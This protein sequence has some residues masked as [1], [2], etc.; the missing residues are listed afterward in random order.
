MPRKVELYLKIYPNMASLVAA[1]SI[2]LSI[3]C[4]LCTK[5]KPLDQDFS[6]SQRKKH[7]KGNPARCMECI[8]ISNPTPPPT[9]CKQSLAAV[10]HPNYP[11]IRA[12]EHVPT[13]TSNDSQ[14]PQHPAV[15]YWLV[16]DFEATCNDKD[17][18]WKNEII[19]WPCVL[20][21]TQTHR[22]VDEFRS[23]VR[24]TE[25]PTLTPFCTKLT[26]IEQ[27]DIAGAPTLEEVLVD[28]DRWLASHGISESGALSVWCGDW[29]LKTCL[30]NECRRKGLFGLVSPVLRSWCNVKFAFNEVRGTRKRMGMDRMLET[31]GLELTGHH[32]LGIDD[33]HN[34]A[35]IV[36]ELARCGG[37]A[38]IEPTTSTP[39]VAIYR[40][41]QWPDGNVPIT[42]ESLNERIAE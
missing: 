5:T 34:I 16:M 23:M 15:D 14:K 3:E 29:D 10:I 8:E 32:H 38:V 1:K 19:E 41:R 28:F 30:P 42:C 31:L 40:R 11:S 33:A 2:S 4:S 27:D 12:V 6:K 25:R 35:K 37:N 39:D 24:P 17:R 18:K 7:L 9:C 20:I 21:S 26:S 13:T 36:C 22:I